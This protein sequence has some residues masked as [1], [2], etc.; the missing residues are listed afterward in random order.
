MVQ[1]GYYACCVTYTCGNGEYA[2]HIQIN[3]NTFNLK[4]RER[5]E[6][7]LGECDQKWNIN[8]K[9]FHSLKHSFERFLCK[10][11]CFKTVQRMVLKEHWKHDSITV[12]P[13]GT[14]FSLIQKTTNKNS[15]GVDKKKFLWRC[16]KLVL[17]V[18]HFQN[19]FQ[20]LH[21]YT[22]IQR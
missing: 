15:C 2:K 13:E 14:T 4:S 3:E 6:E 19:T 11:K 20:A 17:Q 16:G 5:V 8:L 10:Q 9:A 22:N 7:K 21:I 1:L 12:S 18:V